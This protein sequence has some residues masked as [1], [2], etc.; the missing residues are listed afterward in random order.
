MGGCW[1]AVEVVVWNALRQI[2]GMYYLEN[3]SGVIQW[4]KT[5]F[6]SQRKWEDNVSSDVAVQ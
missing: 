6:G 5:S 3:G 1:E 2:E 4:C